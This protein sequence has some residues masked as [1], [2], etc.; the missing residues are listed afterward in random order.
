MCYFADLAALFYALLCKEITW[1]W[2]DTEESAIHSLCIELCSLTVL[3]LPN[4]TKPFQIE[5][6]ALDT[7][8]EGV[9]MQ[10]HASLHKP[11]AILS[12][13]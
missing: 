13:T 10:E 1:H 7:A 9:L 3:A 12:K 6:S 2:T 8:G 5:S 11:F 4:F